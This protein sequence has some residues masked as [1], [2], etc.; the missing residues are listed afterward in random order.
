MTKLTQKSQVTIPK[1]IRKELGLKPGDEVIFE[2]K[3]G[4]V[5]LRK[6]KKQIP[7]NKWAGALGTFSTDEAMTELR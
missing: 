1:E 3:N 6:K 4:M 5:L 7:W 2:E